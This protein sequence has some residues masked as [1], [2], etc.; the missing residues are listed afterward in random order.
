VLV[1]ARTGHGRVVVTGKVYKGLQAL[2]RALKPGRAA[3]DLDVSML[4]ARLLAPALVALALTLVPAGA[5]AAKARDLLPDLDQA[6]VGCP[7]GYAG[8]PMKCKD[9]DI[10]MVA[11]ASDPGAACETDGDI[12][13]VRLRFT[14]SEDNVG[15]G[16]LL[17]YGHRAPGAPR[18]TV[19]QA[20]ATS[21]G[22][23]PQTAAAAR[24]AVA[25]PA[26]NYIYYE[27]ALAH[28]HWHLMNFEH[29]QLRGTGGNTLVN[30][31]KNG[32]C[33]GDR[34]YAAAHKRLKNVPEEIKD[35]KPLDRLAYDLGHYDP[36]PIP[37]T[38]NC[39]RFQTPKSNL[40]SLREG[41]SAGYGDDYD[42]RLDYQ[43]LDITHVPSGN[44]LVVNEVNA[45]HV[46]RE[47]RYGNNTASILI[48]I[49]W[50]AGAAQPPAQITEPP[51]VTLLNSCP[52]SARCAPKASVARAA[53]RARVG[54]GGGA[55]E[56]PLH[57]TALS[58]PVTTVSPTV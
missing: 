47:K 36:R 52:D 3:A 53:V 48:S 32:V 17:V 12:Q 38:S 43:W 45:S 41:I 4:R 13:A 24:H 49:Q 42:Y 6:P 30:D 29:F 21:N 11:D 56:C 5:R 20:F 15:D 54:F 10:C 2:I 58:E 40:L 39:H 50:P 27:P 44:Y 9:W 55:Y 7:G 51:L 37:Q 31:V 28:R 34:Y 33:L 26:A 23:V 22:A 19:R 1:V 25:N 35:S 18:M 8:D 14:S 46:L 16:P 57:D